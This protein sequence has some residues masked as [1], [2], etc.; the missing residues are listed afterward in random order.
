MQ[1][2]EENE[3]CYCESTQTLTGYAVGAKVGSVFSLPTGEVL[4]VVEID[5][6]SNYTIFIAKAKRV[7]HGGHSDPLSDSPT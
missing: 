3:Y 7:A 2:L 6:Y 1:R 4:K 5:Y